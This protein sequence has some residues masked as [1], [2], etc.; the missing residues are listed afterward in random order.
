MA[1][2]PQ[3]Y[4]GFDH[5]A[6][7]LLEGAIQKSAA[8]VIVGHPSGLSREREENIAHLQTF[9]ENAARYRDEGMLIFSTVSNYLEKRNAQ[10]GIAA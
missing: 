6:V 9:L 7:T 3:H 1:C 5:G 10:D 4:C 2:I 8:I